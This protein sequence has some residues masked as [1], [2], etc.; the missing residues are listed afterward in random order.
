MFVV[1]CCLLANTNERGSI[2]NEFDMLSATRINGSFSTIL[3]SFS[4]TV[5]RM[6]PAA[7]FSILLTL[8]LPTLAEP[9]AAP[10]VAKRT[11]LSKVGAVEW[12]DEYFWLRDRE[13]PAVLKYLKAENAYLDSKMPPDGL[14]KK[15]YDEMRSRVVEKDLSV[16]EKDGPFLYYRRNE[17]GREYDIH[18]RK[19]DKPNA[20]EEVWLDENLLAKGHA[21]FSL[22]GCMLS[23]DHRKVA[24]T[25]NTTGTDI[26]QLRV[27]DLDT[28]NELSDKLDN[29]AMGEPGV[30]SADATMLFYVQ[31]DDTQRAF[32]LFRH[33]LGTPQKDDALILEESDG[34]FSVEISK[35][36][37]G[38]YLFIRIASKET[39]EIRFLETAKPEGIPQP[40]VSRTTGVLNGIEHQGGRFLRLTNE[41]AVNFR[42]LTAP[43]TKPSEWKELLPYDEKRYLTSFI[44]ADHHLVIS[45]REG[46]LPMVWIADLPADENASMPPP[47]KVKFPDAAGSFN[48]GENAEMSSPFVR[49][50]Y[51][52]IITPRTVMNIDLKTGESTVLKT[53]EVRG[54]DLSRY[55]VKLV[56][57]KRANGPAI[58]IILAR[59]KD[60]PAGPAPVLL[61]GYGAYGLCNDAFFSSTVFTLLD[62]GFVYALPSLRGGSEFG[63]QWY[64]DGKMSNKKNTFADFIH[65]A[66]WLIADGITSKEKLCIMG[67][68][69]GGILV[70]NVIN[71]RPGLF[72]AAVADVPFVDCL[73]T[74]CDAT[75]PLTV[76][77]YEEWGDPNEK[78]SFDYIR[79][80]APYENVKKQAYPPML[81]TGGWNDP[82]VPYWEPT[83]WVAKLR[84]LKTDDNS[85]YLHTH[86]EAGHGGASGRFEYLKDVAL[87]YAF[88]LEMMHLK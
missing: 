31:A 83:K 9:L 75:L 20:R 7:S 47:R 25:V 18:C 28:G 79:S 76:G 27:R 61:E 72:A 52:S 57:T 22:G 15:L 80:Y 6:N 13:N 8:C 59:K 68:S 66:E 12:Q 74:M 56:L 54:V 34:R 41:G 29:V 40:L 81:V 32:K 3:R 36:R 67:A 45:G 37:S 50:T 62:R 10:Q 86:L 85:L 63:R 69:A 30:W 14:R 60:R 51:E 23:P 55:E 35:S 19:A 49:L 65:A 39:C 64:L 77:E 16:P 58:P 53:Q 84:D 33:K 44:P 82:R 88:L 71:E 48:F 87:S 2:S 73:N 11:H 1:K 38:V 42:L 70:G 46:G 4:Y 5:R 24:Y 17:E 43:V 21:H 78:P 26:Y